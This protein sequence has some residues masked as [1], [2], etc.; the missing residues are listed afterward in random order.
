MDTQK[1]HLTCPKSGNKLTLFFELITPKKAE[2]YLAS[3]HDNNRKIKDR[4]VKSYVRQMEK[5]LWEPASMEP[6]KFSKLKKLI[7]GQHRLRA[8]VEFGKPVWMLCVLGCPEETITVIDSGAKRT[9]SDA[10][11]INN[12]K[13]PN[14]TAIN[15]AII[16]LHNLQR[17][18]IEDTGLEQARS[19]FKNSSI[20]LLYFLDTLPKFPET[21]ERFFKSYRYSNLGKNF[22]IGLALGVFYLFGDE[23]HELVHKIFKA[24]EESIPADGLGSE[25]PMYHVITRSRHNR[26]YKVRARQGDQLNSVLWAIRHTKLGK[27]VKR[28]PTYEQLRTEFHSDNEV[29]NNAKKRL[30]SF[31]KD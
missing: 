12:K 21:A 17:A 11:T 30:M 24:Y 23:D 3:N 1:V 18:F 6:I 25:S 16:F 20:E 13:L 8:I 4:N 7:D 22:P 5:D 10:L 2:K 9:L 27:P 15:G 26:D 29:L 19:N 14:Q 31:S 28:M